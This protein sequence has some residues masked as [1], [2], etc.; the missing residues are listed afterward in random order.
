MVGNIIIAVVIALALAA[1]ALWGIYGDRLRLPPF[2]RKKQ[3]AAPPPRKEPVFNGGGQQSLALD[4]TP[5]ALPPLDAAW[6]PDYCYVVH[7]YEER[8]Q[9]AMRFAAL[10]DQLR[11]RQISLYRLL[12]FN[13]DTQQW[14]IAEPPQSYRYWIAMMP[15]ANRGGSLGRPRI[16]LVEE[17][18]R[19]FAE[20]SGQRVALPSL[21]GALERAKLLDE[22]CDAVDVVLNLRLVLGEPLPPADAEELLQRAYMAA[23]GQRYVY[24]L[25]SEVMFSATP[26]M[27]PNSLVQEIVFK[28]DAPRV[29]QPQ[30]AFQDM[31]QRMEEIAELK[32]GT[33]YDR[34]DNKISEADLSV[35]RGGVERVATEMQEKGVAPGSTLAHLLFD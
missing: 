5:P 27:L 3:P 2:L 1:T 30:R 34:K 29:S 7:F 16:K 8:V 26:V 11:Q 9:D 23:D 17:D 28:L 35:M 22:F 19:R 20:K 32:Q 14:E 31:V 24:R 21:N 10:K 4:F 6:Q 25:D 33:L 13:E 15:L 18:C 12:G